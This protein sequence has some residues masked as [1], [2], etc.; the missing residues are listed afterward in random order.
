MKATFVIVSANLYAVMGVQVRETKVVGEEDGACSANSALIGGEEGEQ[1][2]EEPLRYP[3]S[4]FL[5][6]TC[7]SGTPRCS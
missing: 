6:Q 4:P 7:R 3:S 2:K 1:A 5:P